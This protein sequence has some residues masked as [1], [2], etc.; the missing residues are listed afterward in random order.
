MRMNN[1]LFDSWHQWKV[2]FLS[3]CKNAAW[4]LWRIISCL[5]FGVVTIIVCCGKQIEAFCRR[6]MIAAFIIGIIILFL[7]FGWISTFVQMRVSVMTAEH[8]RDSI[9]YTLDKYMQAFDSTST[10][11]VDNDTIRK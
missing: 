4:G 6:E 3:G 5:L 7:V 9:G 11:I 2:C 1:Q 8:Q 10:I